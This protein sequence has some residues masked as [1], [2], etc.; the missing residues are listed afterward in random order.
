MMCSFWIVNLRKLA[1]AKRECGDIAYD[2]CVR[3][4]VWS[5]S[6]KRSNGQFGGLAGCGDSIN[7]LEDAPPVMNL[8]PLRPAFVAPETTESNIG[9]RR[10]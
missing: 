2:V 1:N 10:R 4:Q 7:V 8:A 5:A 3:F 6:S 9:F